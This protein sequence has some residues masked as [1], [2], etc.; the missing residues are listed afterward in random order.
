MLTTNFL[1][2]PISG[3]SFVSQMAF[4]RLFAEIGYRPN[5]ILSASGGS[6]SAF[7]ANCCDWNPDK[8]T[9]VFNDISSNVFIL[10]PFSIVSLLAFPFRLSLY[11]K[12]PYLQRFIKENVVKDPTQP[13]IEQWALTVNTDKKLPQMNCNYPIGSTSF[14]PMEYSTFV[15]TYHVQ[16]GAQEMGEIVYASSAVPL[17][18]QPGCVNGQKNVDGGMCLASPLSLL[19]SGM[20]DMPQRIQ[21][22]Y[23]SSYNVFE[24]IGHSIT[25]GS[26]S[27]HIHAI[28][29]TDVQRGIDYLKIRSQNMYLIEEFTDFELADWLNTNKEKEYFLYCCPVDAISVNM[30]SFTSR[31]FIEAVNTVQFK[32]KAWIS[33]Q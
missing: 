2:A 11:Y 33:A 21:M 27:V 31:D 28:C 30:V 5:I 24:G 19:C 15:T 23:V 3:G 14:D 6:V 16:N 20:V 1:I 7:V 26:L 17:A 18:M 9:T 25:T 8:M 29:L 10:R 4:F 32:F 22:V 12:S 13:I